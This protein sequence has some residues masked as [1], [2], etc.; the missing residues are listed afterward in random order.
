MPGTVLSVS[1]KQLG[2]G[3]WEAGR[4]TNKDGPP[5]SPP[6]SHSLVRDRLLLK[7]CGTEG[8]RWDGSFQ[9]TH[10]RSIRTQEK[11]I[12]MVFAV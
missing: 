5:P 2:G 4:R 12:G 7:Y 11:N 10:A 6:D 9:G 1:D 8:L 3:G